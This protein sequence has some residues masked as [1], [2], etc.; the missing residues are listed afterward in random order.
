MTFT[1]M[2]RVPWEPGD[3]EGAPAPSAPRA[4]GKGEENV[5]FHSMH[6]LG[7]TMVPRHMANI[8]LDV[9]VRMLLDEIS[10]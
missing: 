2:N 7:W 5:M 10:M 8:F 4:A 6:Q 1:Q 3:A 9:T